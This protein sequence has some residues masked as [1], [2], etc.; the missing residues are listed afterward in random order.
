LFKRKQAQSDRLPPTPAALHQ[1]ILRA[2]YQL[3][4]W[5]ND[6]VANPDLPSPD[7]YGWVMNEEWNPVMT[8]LPPA[9]EAVIQLVKCKCAK[10]QCSSK[11]CQ[12]RK[13]GLCCTDLCYCSENGCTNHQEDTPDISD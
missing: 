3:I 8:T 5:N 13:S 2:H 7:M 9:P 6:I 10:D 11:R 4:V 1:A 12:C